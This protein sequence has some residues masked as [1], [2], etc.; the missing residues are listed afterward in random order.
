MY[1]YDPAADSWQQL[2]TM[3]TAKYSHAA[4][5]LDGKI[6]VTGGL[7]SST[8]EYTDALE[9]YDPASN[10]WTTLARM[11]DRRAHHSSVVVDGELCVFGG[12]AACLWDPWCWSRTEVEVYSIASDCW[13]RAAHLPSAR[14]EEHE[15][16]GEEDDE[17]DDDE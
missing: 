6:Y 1:M 13:A 11:H 16:R 7:L 14:A 12:F 8:N 4:A 3:P 17:G 9:V 10:T 15:E 2:A 5:V